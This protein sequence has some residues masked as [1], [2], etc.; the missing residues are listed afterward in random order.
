MAC[1]YFPRGSTRCWIFQ[2]EKPVSGASS[3]RQIWLDFAQA[4]FDGGQLE[5]KDVDVAS[6]YTDA[7]VAKFSDFDTAKVLEQAKTY[8]D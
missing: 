1:A 5:T 2:P 7:L 8:K 3:M 4:L 6:C